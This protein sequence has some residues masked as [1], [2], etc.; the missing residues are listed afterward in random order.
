MKKGQKTP[1]TL[2][3]T[4][5]EGRASLHL[6]WSWPGR[7]P[8]IVPAAALNHKE[9]AKIRPVDLMAYKAGKWLDFNI[10]TDCWTG[11]Y[12][13]A[14]NGRKVLKGAK[15]AEP[16]SMV[17]AL[18]FRTGEYRGDPGERADRD[19]P[20]TE[21]PLTKVTYRIDDVVTGK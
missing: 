21:E 9:E 3:F 13:L 5:A 8:T 2:E 4:S 11:K 6:S 12:T 20:N 19:I 10:S 18:S 15:F 7:V 16:S 14:V 17:Y 1:I